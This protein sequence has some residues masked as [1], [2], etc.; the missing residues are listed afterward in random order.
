MILAA[1][2][3]DMCLS[4]SWEMCHDLGG[5]AAGTVSGVMNTFGNVGG[6][7]SP[8]VVGYAVQWWGSWAIPL[9][10]AAAVAVLGGVFT[11][12]IDT[13]ARATEHQ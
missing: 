13:T 3:G 2:F 10:I 6:S 7:L 11:L 1:S 8:L 9:L 4:P 12:L 5:D